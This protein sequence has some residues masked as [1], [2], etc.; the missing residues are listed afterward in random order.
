MNVIIHTSWVV[1]GGMNRQEGTEREEEEEEKD[2]DSSF[3]PDCPDGGPKDFGPG[4]NGPGGFGDG[5]GFGGTG[6]I[7]V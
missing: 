7:A 1:L 5:A 4:G 3:C 6:G 2:M